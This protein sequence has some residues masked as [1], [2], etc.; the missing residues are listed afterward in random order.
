M[1]SSGASERGAPDRSG[2]APRIVSISAVTLATHDMARA[3]RF[4]RA[5]GFEL[6]YGGEHAAFTSF[7]VGQGHLN[8]TA[9]PPERQWSWWGRVVLYVEDVDG[10]Y[11]RARAHGLEPQAVPRDAE[12]GERYFHITD[13]D[14]H[15]LSFARPL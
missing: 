3:V 11:A 1:G 5:L 9:A 15:E 7:S 2:A 13:P 4:Y 6:A 10:L 12:W 8:L 14:G